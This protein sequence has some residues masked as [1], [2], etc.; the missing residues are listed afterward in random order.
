MPLHEAS[1]TGVSIAA[2]RALHR[3]IIKAVQKEKWKDIAYK[4]SISPLET[5]LWFTR[6]QTILT[7]YLKVQETSI[8]LL[9]H[10]HL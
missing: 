1:K 10:R 7:F 6:N 4:S 2:N 5:I 3:R 9:D 8:K